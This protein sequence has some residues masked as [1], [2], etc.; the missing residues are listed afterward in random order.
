MEVKFI[1]ITGGSGAGKSTLCNALKNKYPDRIE[2]IQL[3][4]YFKPSAERPKI[5]DISN[6]DHPEALYLDKLAEDLGKL[7]KGKSIFIKTKN[8]YLNPEFGKTKEKILAEFYPK[9]IILVEGF[10][11]L[12]DEQIRKLLNTSIWLDV[13]HETRWSRRVHFKDEEYEKK[14]LIPMHN[15][16]TEPT[17]QYAEHIIDVSALDREQ[18]L[19]KVEKIIFD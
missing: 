7:K 11:V 4:D 12:Y 8:E 2:L 13:G 3:D 5:G 14:V 17:K 16:Y 10:L 6:F 1:G 18:V 9:P 19:E 15:K